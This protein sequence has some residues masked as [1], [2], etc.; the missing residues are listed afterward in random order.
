MLTNLD[1]IVIVFM[2]LAAVGL[3]AL[4]LMFLVKN[5]KIRKGSILVASAL[6]AYL[7]YVG[8]RI[9]WPEFMGQFVIGALM[10]VVGVGAIVLAVISKDNV[11]KFNIARV[12]AAVSLVLGMVNAIL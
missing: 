9:G 6:G 1:L 3:L 2:V 5:E 12:L 11:K 10:A 4:V 8:F 7:G